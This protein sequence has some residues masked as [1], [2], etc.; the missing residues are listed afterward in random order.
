MVLITKLIMCSLKPDKQHIIRE[1]REF[2]YS[3][4]DEPKNLSHHTVVCGILSLLCEILF[5]CFF[6]RLRISQRQKKVGA[7]NFARVFDYDPDRSSPLSWTLAHRESRGRRH[8]YGPE[9]ARRV[10]V[11]RHMR[12]GSVGIGNWGRRRRVR[13]IFW[14]LRLDRYLPGT[15]HFPIGQLPR[16]Y[17]IRNLLEVYRIQVK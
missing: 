2:I 11:V 16:C 5:V 14:D 12:R 1:D 10:L 4:N 17:D 13:R 3:E 9:F 6:V 7:W 15:Y 8:M